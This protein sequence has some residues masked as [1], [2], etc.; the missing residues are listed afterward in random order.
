MANEAVQCF[1]KASDWVMIG[2]ALFLGACALFVPYLAEVIKRRWFAPNL[3]IIFSQSPPFCHLT[4]RGD[5]SP[6]YYFRFQVLNE[7]KSQAKFCEA[8]LTELWLA[9][10]S[11]HFIKEPNFSSINL[12]WSGLGKQFV[13][14]NPGRELFCDIGHISSPLL[15]ERNERSIFYVNNQDLKFFFETPFR[16]FSQPDSVLPGK[17]RIKISFYSENAPK[18]EKYFEIIWSGKWQEKESDMFREFVIR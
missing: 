8:V 5:G 11:G 4:K 16:F 17:T 3:K 7:G 1:L 18:V 14:I 9:D 13:D 15:Q 10:I 12:N 6:V 2:T